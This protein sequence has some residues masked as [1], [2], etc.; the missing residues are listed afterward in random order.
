MADAELFQWDGTV[1]APVMLLYNDDT[2]N[3]MAEAL[4]SSGGCIAL[5]SS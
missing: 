5:A 4:K 2:V 3:F 1:H